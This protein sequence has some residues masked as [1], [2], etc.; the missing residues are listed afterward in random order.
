MKVSSFNNAVVQVININS[1]YESMEEDIIDQGKY[2]VK[3]TQLN[4]IVTKYNMQGIT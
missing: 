1:L 2:I 4:L 3:I